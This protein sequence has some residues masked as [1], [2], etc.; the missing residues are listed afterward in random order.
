MVPLSTLEM[1]PAKLIGGLL[2]RVI[3]AAALWR[4][5]LPLA[6]RLTAGPSK[7]SNTPSSAPAR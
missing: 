2:A 4:F 6:L 1:S 5:V 3:V 7:T